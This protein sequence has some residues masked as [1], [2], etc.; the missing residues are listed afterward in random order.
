[1]VKSNLINEFCIE[2]G[3]AEWLGLILPAPM[4]SGL[5]QPEEWGQC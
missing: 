2:R 1:M 3:A 4:T 5:G